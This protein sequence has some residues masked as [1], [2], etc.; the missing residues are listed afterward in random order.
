LINDKLVFIPPVGISVN[1]PLVAVPSDLDSGPSAACHDST[2]NFDSFF[3][4]VKNTLVVDKNRQSN[5]RKFNNNNNN[6]NSYDMLQLHDIEE[7][8]LELV[9]KN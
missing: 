5:L 1:V 8:L 6:N 9:D 4:L 3:F 7:K 2:Q